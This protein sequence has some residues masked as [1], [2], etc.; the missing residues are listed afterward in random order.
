M[1][2]LLASSPAITISAAFATEKEMKLDGQLS[3][4]QWLSAKT[5]STFYQVVPATLSTHKDKIEG[6]V[7]SNE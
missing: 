7:Y 1:K 2:T 6:R 4:V 5:Y 3:E